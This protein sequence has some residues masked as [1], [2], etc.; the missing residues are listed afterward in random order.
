MLAAF[1]GQGHEHELAVPNATFSHQ[2][3]CER[4]HGIHGAAQHC[5]FQAVVMV[6]MDMQ[7]RQADVMVVVLKGGQATGELTLV[8]VVDEAHRRRTF[9]L[10]AML[11]DL[12][13][14]ASPQEVSKCLG[15]RGV[16]LSL[17]PLVEGVS[18]VVVQR[19][20]HA[21]HWQSI[22]FASKFSSRTN[23]SAIP[24]FR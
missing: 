12:G 13:F 5:R 4:P 23:T 19:K 20:C 3:L 17:G 15:T 16:L 7:R 21:A 14:E 9:P 6:E 18:K 2:C 24:G 8:M 10:T 11:D 1:F 22:L